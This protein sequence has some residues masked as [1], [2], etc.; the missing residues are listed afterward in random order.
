MP[1]G[2]C[3]LSRPPSGPHRPGGLRCPIDYPLHRSL[4][5]CPCSFPIVQLAH[6][7]CPTRQS[8]TLLRPHGHHSRESIGKAGCP[9]KI[10]CNTPSSG[11]RCW[12]PPQCP[13]VEARCDLFYYNSGTPSAPGFALQND[14]P[15]KQYMS[16]AMCLRKNKQAR[17]TPSPCGVA[18][19]AR[20]VPQRPSS[21]GLAKQDSRKCSLETTYQMASHWAGA[22][23][24]E[25]VTVVYQ[26]DAS[27]KNTAPLQTVKLSSIS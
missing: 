10:P 26:C 9:G 14:H 1:F 3:L 21:L 22:C 17:T 18:R 11:I 16:L 12:R 19:F 20:R 27:S 8:C 4:Q 15:S 13:S 7:R 5:F 25:P 24:K 2:I 23:S 6:P